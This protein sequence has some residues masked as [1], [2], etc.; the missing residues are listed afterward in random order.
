MYAYRHLFHAG[1]FADVFKHALLAQLV[2]A[3]E[4]KDKP[5]LYLDTHAG[6]GRYDLKHP[7]AQKNREFKHGLARVWQRDDV[8]EL[9]A[10][11]LEAV[12][13]F[14]PGDALREYPGSPMFVQRLLRPD[15]RMVLCEL[16]TKDHAT[17]KSNMAGD[18]RVSAHH[19]D[20]FTAVRA[21]LP[22][23]ERRGL[24]LMDPAFD[25]PGEFKR[26]SDALLTAHQRFAT[27]V[28]AFWYP[29]MEPVAMHRFEEDIAA[30]GVPRILQLELSVHAHGAGG[31]LR[32]CGLLVVNPPFGFEAEARAIAKW[33]APILAEGRGG[34]QRIR[35]LTGEKIAREPVDEDEQDPA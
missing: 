19:L 35:W 11:W 21:H 6:L 32:G 4:K 14:N 13:A 16:N 3:L 5:I 12:R 27:G 7:W 29:M 2:L 24:M 9:L 18:A 17:L 25:Q 33:L 15:D 34:K 30:C 28:L 10:P 8:P 1:N 22:P 31:G 26:L 23:R 20:G